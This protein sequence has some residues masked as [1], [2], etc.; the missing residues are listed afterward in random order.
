MGTLKSMSLEMKKDT[1]A[2]QISIRGVNKHIQ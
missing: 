1:L 2:E